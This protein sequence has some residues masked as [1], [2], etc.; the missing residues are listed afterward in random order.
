MTTQAYT[1]VGWKP[2]IH[3]YIC[4]YYILCIYMGRLCFCFP[5]PSLP[6][7]VMCLGFLS[8]SFSPNPVTRS[9]WT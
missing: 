6:L 5:L 4:I 2:Y 9:R 7:T 3:I 8:S 1:G